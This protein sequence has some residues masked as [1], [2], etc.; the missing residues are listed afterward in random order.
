VKGGKEEGGEI[1]G[2]GEEGSRTREIRYL[3]KNDDSVLLA[4]IKNLFEVKGHV[5]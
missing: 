3:R 2:E 5:S 1:G 4:F